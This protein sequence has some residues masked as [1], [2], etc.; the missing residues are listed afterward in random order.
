MIQLQEIYCKN[1]RNLVEQNVILNPGI[2]I[3]HGKNGSGKTSFLEGIH[4]LATG[5]SFRNHITAQ[6]VKHEAEELCL[7]GVFFDT[8]KKFSTTLAIIKGRKTSQLR[9]NQKRETQLSKLARVVPL[10]VITQESHKLLQEGPQWRRRF[11]DW[12]L[13][14]VEQLCSSIWVDFNK[15]LKHR[16]RLLQSGPVIQDKHFLLWTEKVAML[17]QQLTEYRQNYLL[18]LA[19][20]IPLISA[21][22]LKN[23]NIQ[24]EF[25]RGWKKDCDLYDSL[26]DNYAKDISTKVTSVGPQRADFICKFESRKANGFVSRGQQKL[27]IYVLILAQV[28]H[29]KQK[30]NKNVILLIDE[31]SAEL[32]ELNLIQLLKLLE[33]YLP[34]T[35][36]TTANAKFIPVDVLTQCKMFHVEQGMIEAA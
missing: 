34:Q 1:I 31:L 20:Y 32:D 30:I 21:D 24:L 13:F 16:N 23:V 29:L 19:E 28:C 17:G 9:I 14:H 10:I 5:K 36:I 7:K 26:I 22:L 15:A 8:Q 4:L 2:N 18:E 25:K 3:F 6:I 27:L 11:I 35:F 12:G 33:K